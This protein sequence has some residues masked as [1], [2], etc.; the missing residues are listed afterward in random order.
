MGV[1]DRSTKQRLV[2][3]GIGMISPSSGLELV[4]AIL[5]SA[6]HPAILTAVPFDWRRFLHREM[7]GPSIIF[8]E[9]ADTYA[10]TTQ[11]IEAQKPAHAG[12]DPSTVQS[13]VQEIVGG[14]LGVA[15]GLNDPLMAAGLDSLGAV[16]LRNDLE[17]AF[18]CKLPSTVVFDYPTVGA[19]AGFLATALDGRIVE[20]PRP[21]SISFTVHERLN[22]PSVALSALAQRSPHQG[23][24]LEG[25]N[26]A[27]DL[28]ATVPLERW[29]VDNDPLMARFGAYLHDVASFDASAFSISSTEASLMDPQQRLLLEVVL[30]NTVNSGSSQDLAARG[31]YVGVA[32]SDY[33]SLLGKYT[34]KGAFHATATAT[35]VVCGRVS[36]TMGFRGP[37]MSVETACSASLVA[38]HL[39]VRSIQNHESPLSTA[40]GVHIQ[41][42]QLSASYVAA[43]GM[44]SPEGRCKTL[45]ASADGYVRGES[46]I[47]VAVMQWPAE[48]ARAAFT[49]WD[50]AV[51][52]RGSAVNQDGRSSTLTAPNGPAQ[53]E[54]LRAALADASVH[55]EAVTGLSMH[56]TG[57]SLGDPIEVGASLAVFGSSDRL[58]PLDFFASKS[59]VGHGEPSAGLAGIAFGHAAVTSHWSVPI[60][61]LRATNPYVSDAINTFK[62]KFV[63]LPRH[64]ASRPTRGSTDAVGVSA[65]AFQGTNA[66]VL[67]STAADRGSESHSINPTV[68]SWRHNRYYVLPPAHALVKLALRSDTRMLFNANLGAPE[69]AFIWDHRVLQRAIVPGKFICNY[70]AVVISLILSHLIFFLFAQELRILSSPAPLLFACYPTLRLRPQLFLGVVYPLHSFFHRFRAGSMFHW[71]VC[72]D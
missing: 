11:V 2:R 3:S 18:D 67:I 42:A 12:V 68:T 52:V 48:S 70:M 51:V 40:A 66:H 34:E 55:P 46:C 57:T 71:S 36:Y 37:S 54:L 53:Q 62:D 43:A 9:F 7:N 4:H 14:I 27:L 69:L 30:E 5:L 21:E 65:F 39:A 19:L 35:S 44:L 41:C 33:V 56:G 31:L 15:V 1:A 50:D 32:A 28:V 6:I 20:K 24:S 61:H 17:A 49:L 58:W 47:A 26:Q 60:M 23:L 63:F 64:P 13:K 25:A 29:D 59:W 38:T 8:S 72:C 22:I 16:E 10:E 45:D